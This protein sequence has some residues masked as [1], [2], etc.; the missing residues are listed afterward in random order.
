VPPSA[1]CALGSD[2]DALFASLDQ[3]PSAVI[4]TSANG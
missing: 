3:I 2:F 4:S 1:S